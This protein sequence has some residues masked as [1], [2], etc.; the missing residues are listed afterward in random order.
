MTLHKIKFMESYSTIIQIE[1][2]LTATEDMFSRIP[3]PIQQAILNCH[4]EPA[5]LQHCLRWGLQAVKE[6]R[7]DWH[8][9][10]SDIPCV[11]R[12]GG[13]SD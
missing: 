6:V 7:T 1:N 3:L 9:V 11:E 4:R 8:T 13:D 2:L 5:T 12:D 10:V